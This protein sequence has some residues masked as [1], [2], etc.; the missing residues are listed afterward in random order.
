MKAVVKRVAFREP[1]SDGP[2]FRGWTY[3]IEVQA[4]DGSVIAGPEGGIT[5][6]ATTMQALADDINTEVRS[7]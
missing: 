3:A 4:D 2:I 1:D 5:G 7:C 6:P